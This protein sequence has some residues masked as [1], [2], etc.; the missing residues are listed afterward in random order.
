MAIKFKFNTNTVDDTAV[1][2]TEGN[3]YLDN[4]PDDVTVGNLKSIEKYNQQYI[5]GLTKAASKEAIRSFNGSKAVKN[6]VT[7]APFGSDNIS[8]ATVHVK[9]T[10]KRMN[11]HT[12][13][14]FNTPS[15]RTVVNWKG[16]KGSKKIHGD[17]LDAMRKEISGS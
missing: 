8:T 9:R 10:T 16:S 15:I 11:P 3:P 4:L 17:I 14:S 13:K 5:N 12:G 2:K 7:T 1:S 6:T